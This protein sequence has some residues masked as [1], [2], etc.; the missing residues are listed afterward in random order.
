MTTKSDFS[1]EEWKLLMGTPPLVGT[2]VMVS[3]RSGLGSLKEAMAVAQGVMAATSQFPNSTLIQALMQARRDGERSDVEKLSGPYLRMN[4]Q[5]LAEAAVT[6]CRAATKIVQERCSADDLKA[7]QAWIAGLARS[8]A[9]AAK[10]GA[11]L[12]LGGEKVSDPEKDMLAR[13]E[14]AMACS[15]ESGM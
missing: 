3:G 14:Q 8:V 6:Q 13:L 4:P 11:F 7:F 15:P 12:G 2:A 5:E 10:E 1:E 9:E